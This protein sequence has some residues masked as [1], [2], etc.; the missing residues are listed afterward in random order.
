MHGKMMMM[1]PNANDF[2]RIKGGFCSFCILFILGCVC[3]GINV[4]EATIN[5]DFDRDRRHTDKKTCIHKHALEKEKKN[6]IDK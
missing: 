5:L 1:W 2:G 6:K 4:C 3:L